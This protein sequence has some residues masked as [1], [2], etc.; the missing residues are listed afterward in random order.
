MGLRGLPTSRNPF[1]PGAELLAQP[2]AVTTQ[3][4]LA[5]V[6]LHPFDVEVDRET[7]ADLGHPYLG[8]VDPERAHAYVEQ[9]NRKPAWPDGPH[10][11]VEVPARRLGRDPASDD[12]PK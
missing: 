9:A 7:Y 2:S 1:A 10:L 8:L 3:R 4:D 6:H 11:D 12:G 5:S